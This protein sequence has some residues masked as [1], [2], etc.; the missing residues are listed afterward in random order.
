MF[1]NESIAGKAIRVL[2]WDIGLEILVWT[3]ALIYLAVFNPYLQS[4]FTICPFSR[5]GFHHCP[6]CGLG[7][8]VSFLLHGDL[9]L[10]LQTHILG[11][12]ATVVLIYR[13]ISLLN[14]AL[15]KKGLQ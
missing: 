11:V 8:A 12:P 4:D 1:G 14:Q 3:S 6:G 7:R 2:Y 15:R 5:L 10:S 13:I 9:Q